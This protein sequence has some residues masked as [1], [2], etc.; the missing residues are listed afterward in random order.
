MFKNLS[1]TIQNLFSGD[2]TG[3]KVVGDYWFARYSNAFEDREG[4]FF[5]VKA[6]DA[7][8]DRVDVGVVPMP[9]LWV[10]HTPIVIGKAKAIARIGLFVVAAG[11]FANNPLGQAAK[12]YLSK[13]KGKNSH[14]FVFD[15]EW[16]G[17]QMS[18]RI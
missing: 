5:P 15:V 10:W 3:I 17:Q 18:N 11:T 4:E 2:E 7:F 14:G 12:A 13:H 1:R 16:A 9:E 8:I 6:I